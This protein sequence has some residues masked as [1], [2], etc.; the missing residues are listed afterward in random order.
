MTPA[1]VQ[2]RRERRLSVKENSRDTW[3]TPKW[4]FR[5]LEMYFWKFDVDAASSKENA[6]CPGYWTRE[7]DA[8]VQ[9][10]TG[11]KVFCNPPFCRGNDILAWLKKGAE[12]RRAVFVLPARTDTKWFAW[13]VENC[14]SIIFVEG[15]INFDPPEGVEKSSNFERTVIVEFMQGHNQSPDVSTINFPKEVRRG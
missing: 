3:R 8:L 12:A 4:L 14:A 9:D 15:R 2:N 5:Q 11:L 1:K 10:W 13:V 7:D 6:L